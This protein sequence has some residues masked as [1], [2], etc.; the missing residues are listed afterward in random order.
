MICPACGSTETQQACCGDTTATCL[1]CGHRWEGPGG[2]A[3]PVQ[4]PVSVPVSR[5]EY[6]ELTDEQLWGE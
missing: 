2:T 6:R 1:R 5:A 3:C 4:V